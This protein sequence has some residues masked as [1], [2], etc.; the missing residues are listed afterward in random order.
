M[1]FRSILVGIVAVAGAVGGLAFYV[2]HQLRHQA[3]WD[4]VQKEAIR[5]N[6]GLRHESLIALRS[7]V[8]DLDAALSGYVQVDPER[9]NENRVRS[10]QQ[11][12]E[13]VEWAID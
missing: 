12:I 4:E 11:A 3:D 9:K 13:S 1:K 8:A 2:H 7:R 10:L 6:A 5:V